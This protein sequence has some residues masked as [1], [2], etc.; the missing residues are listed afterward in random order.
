M[1]SP[2]TPRA[3]LQATSA[4]EASGIKFRLCPERQPLWHLCGAA[5]ITEHLN[6]D[7]FCLFSHLAFWFSK[8]ESGAQ[9]GHSCTASER[10]RQIRTQ[11]TPEPGSFYV[12]HC[13]LQLSAEEP[14]WATGQESCYPNCVTHQL[15]DP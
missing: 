15:E 4:L 5:T 9:G 11:F 2:S 8:E 10:D 13:L 3:G 6:L 12:L 7:A 1:S 14:G